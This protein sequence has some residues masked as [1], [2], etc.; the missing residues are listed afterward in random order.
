MCR[1]KKIDDYNELVSEFQKEDRVLFLSMTY[2]RPAKIERTLERVD[3]KSVVVTDQE[4]KTQES[5]AV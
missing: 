1:N 5:F 3:F 2:E 4:N